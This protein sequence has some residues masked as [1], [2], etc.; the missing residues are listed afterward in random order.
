MET[1]WLIFMGRLHPLV[2]HLPI[3]FLAALLALEAWGKVFERAQVTPMQRGLLAVLFWLSALASAG[4]GWLLGLEDGHASGDLFLHQG[5]GLV[6][7]T[8]LTALAALG[9]RRG[10]YRL[11]LAL[12]ILAVLGAGHLGSSMTQGEAFLA[13]PESEIV[14]V[15]QEQ[16]D[17]TPAPVIPTWY[18]ARI[19]PILHDYCIKCH[20]EKK[21]KGDL[22]LH[23]GEIMLAGSE[24]LQVVIPGDAEA[25]PLIQR[26]RLPRDHEDHMPP[27]AKDQPRPEDLRELA[28]WI[29]AGASLVAAAPEALADE[30]LQ[31]PG[32]VA[33]PAPAVLSAQAVEALRRLQVHVEIIDPSSQLLW[34]NCRP[35]PGVD[36]EFLADYLQPLA[37]FVGEL[38]LAGTAL[39]NAG[40]AALEGMTRLER[41]D[42]SATACGAEGLARLVGLPALRSLNLTN[43]ALGDEAIEI[44]VAMSA[45]ERVQLWGT[46]LSAEGL[47]R[48]R[49]ARPALRLEVGALATLLAL[50]TEPPVSFSK[51]PELDAH[52]GSCPVTQKPVDPRF[53]VVH[54]DRVVGFC[55]PN[56]PS[57][58]LNAPEEYPLGE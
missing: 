32:V 47:A 20:G 22:A 54:D 23:T 42:L 58:F 4:S 48:L 34:I 7:A 55:C 24:F 25:S 10:L 16:P 30:D 57:V 26:L 44:L 51:H 19:A 15:A 1:P 37:G 50:E 3:G 13:K 35:R 9:Q 27:E 28:R 8:T 17:Q 36:D 5:L 49:E 40:L 2:L 18:E 14:A 53:R 45:L 46:G 6:A 12:S 33:E 21:Q 11:S 41:L 43:T 39:G 31:A 52:N 29:A 38:S 56:C